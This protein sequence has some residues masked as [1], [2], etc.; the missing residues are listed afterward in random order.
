[1]K[2]VT[3]IINEEAEEYYSNWCN[4]LYK[5]KLYKKSFYCDIAVIH[6]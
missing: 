3:N 2:D 5:F 4:I 1:L 6:I